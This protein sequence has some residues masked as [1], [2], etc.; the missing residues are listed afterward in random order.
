MKKSWIANGATATNGFFGG[1]SILM[2]IEGAFDYAAVCILVSMVADFMDGRI[3]RALHTTGPLGVELD[4]MCDDISFGIAPGALLY[5]ADLR[6]LGLIGMIAC[7][8]LAV[9]CAFRLAR[10]NVKSD[11]V[12]GYF[13]GLPCPMTG[14]IT[15]GYILSGV[16]LWPIV[17]LLLVLLVAYLMVSEIHYP[18][19][20]GASADQLHIEAL[21]VALLVLI[22]PTFFHW[23][24]W[25]AALCLAFIVFGILNTYM[26]H[27]KMER[28]KRRKALRRR[29]EE[30]ESEDDYL[31]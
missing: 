21:G 25:F 17:T 4:S 20:K 13:E 18:T 22:L 24:V 15:A 8:L 6:E 27:R 26:N 23:P 3:A 7:A 5:A 9:S 12:H 10:F 31:E 30:A 14:M 28:R 1:L 11:E 2:T 19:N 16:K 29:R